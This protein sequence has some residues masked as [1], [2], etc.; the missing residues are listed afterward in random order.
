MNLHLNLHKDQFSTA[1]TNSSKLLLHVMPTAYHTLCGSKLTNTN[2]ESI[3]ECL[4]SNNL[5]IAKKGNEISF[6]NAIRAKVLDFTITKESSLSG[7]S[8]CLISRKI[9]QWNQV[10]RFRKKLIGNI[11][12]NKISI[13]NINKKIKKTPQT[14]ILLRRQFV[15]SLFHQLFTP[16]DAKT[17]HGGVTSWRKN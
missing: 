3:C 4:C 5:T 13:P 12:F 8:S 6:H 11:Q 7:H 10:F 9:N 14:L 17:S 16:K 2:G 1:K 15:T